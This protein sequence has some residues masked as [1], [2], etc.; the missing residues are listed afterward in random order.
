MYSL[1]VQ[2]FTC[3][4]HAIRLLEFELENE[5]LHG[6]EEDDGYTMHDAYE[7]AGM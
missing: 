6:E 7:D 1:Q 5:E 2:K 4:N 3:K